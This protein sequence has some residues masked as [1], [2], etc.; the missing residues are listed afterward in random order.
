[1]AKK[2]ADSEDAKLSD[3]NWTFSADDKAAVSEGATSQNAPPPTHQQSVSWTASEYMAHDKNTMWFMGLGL[4]GVVI[5]GIVFLTTNHDYLPTFLILAMFVIFGVFAA[6]KPENLEYVLD[7]SGL[8]IGP[9]TYPYAR[10]KSFAIMDESGV[11]SI[12]LLPMT[13]FM[14]PLSIYYDHKDEKS[15]VN[16]LSGYLPLEQRDHDL[17][18]QLMRK[19]RF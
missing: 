1:M 15:I 19:I 13:R 12:L 3:S 5:G 7:N 9:K 14:P 8:K 18:D 2:K 17:T 11:P 4:G 10:F 6:R 16:V